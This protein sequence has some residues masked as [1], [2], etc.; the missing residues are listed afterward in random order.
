MITGISYEK[1][2]VMHRAVGRLSFILILLHTLS[3][4]PYVTNTCQIYELTVCENSF[5]SAKLAD[6]HYLTGV[7]GA[8]AFGAL[9]L[10]SVRPVRTHAFEFFLA[11]HICLV[12]IYLVCSYLHQP[13]YVPPYPLTS[14]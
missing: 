12:A 2:N 7:V 1:L 3:K 9:F 6:G 5:P 10:F 11:L 8:T 14:R 13:K 4:A